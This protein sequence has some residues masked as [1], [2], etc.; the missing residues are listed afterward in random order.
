MLWF[1]FYCDSNP[2]LVTWQ[3][4]E[5]GTSIE[6]LLPSDWSAGT[7]E[8]HFLDSSLMQ[9]FFSDNYGYT[10]ARQ[11]SLGCIKNVTEV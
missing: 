3:A 6:E 2:L 10:I 8:E 1:G 5:E 9:D 4:W 11:V 7:F